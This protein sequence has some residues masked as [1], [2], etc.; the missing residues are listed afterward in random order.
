MELLTVIGF[1][2]IATLMVT[3]MC[4]FFYRG[5]PVLAD[6]PSTDVAP[7]PATPS[8]QRRV[9]AANEWYDAAA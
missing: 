8:C 1:I 3:E 9:E 6:G 7:K 5:R 2:G 4:A